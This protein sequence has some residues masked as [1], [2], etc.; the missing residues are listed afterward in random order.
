M[1]T[2][3]A[4][5]CV[6]AVWVGLGFALDRY[7]RWQRWDDE[8]RLERGRKVARQTGYNRVMLPEITDSDIVSIFSNLARETD[9]IDWSVKV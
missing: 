2:E 4:V 5:A 1:W 3:I 6:L 7:L 9:E 8:R